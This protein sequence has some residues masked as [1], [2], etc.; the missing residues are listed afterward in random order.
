[1]I[2]DPYRWTPAK[3]IAIQP[4]AADTVA[5][6]VERPAGF[7]FKA[8]QYSVVKTTLRNG[9]QRIRQYSYSSDPK[10]IEHLEML[11]QKETGGEVSGWF[12]K[13][14]KVG[15]EIEISQALGG[16]VLNDLERP[17]ILIAGKVGVAPFFSMLREGAH[18]A[19]SLIYNVR[20]IK[21]ACYETELQ[22]YNSA[23]LETSKNGHMSQ[24]SLRPFLQNKPV[25]YICGSKQFVD[26]V[27]EML[28]AIG[29]PMT[30]MYRELFTLQ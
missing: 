2:I 8:G 28:L 16:F 5:V 26:A 1:M 18:P 9:E 3:I 15:D 29:V 22:Q 10:V 30:D 6:H 13:E 12:C 7:S 20:N 23:V 19:L 24:S 14:A 4:V 11:I 21:Q 17:T 27:T 25:F